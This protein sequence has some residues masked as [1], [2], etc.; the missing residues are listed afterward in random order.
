[1]ATLPELVCEECGN[2]ASDLTDCGAICDDCADE[3]KSSDGSVESK[4]VSGW[5]RRPLEDASGSIPP[6]DGLSGDIGKDA[7]AGIAQAVKPAQP[8]A[9]N[10]RIPEQPETAYSSDRQVAGLAPGPSE[11]NVAHLVSRPDRASE[12]K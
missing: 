1:M 3:I 5:S 9:R 8:A 10:R 7:L 6:S 12:G 11:E 2:A 4:V